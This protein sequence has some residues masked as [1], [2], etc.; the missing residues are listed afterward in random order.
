MTKLDTGMQVRAVRDI[1]GGV[2][3][4]SVPAGSLGV[5]VSPDDVGCRP[6]V[7][8]VIRGLLGDRQVVTDVDPDDVEPP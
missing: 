4:E 2:M 6:Q 8:F 3:H 1:S 5:V 7:A